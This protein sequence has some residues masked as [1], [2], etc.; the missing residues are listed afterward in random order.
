MKVFIGGSRKIKKLNAQIEDRLYNI[1]NNNYHVLLGDAEGADK[2]VQH[3]FYKQRYSNVN[4]FCSGD[5]CRNNLGHWDIINIPVPTNFRGRKFY[6]VKD[7]AM[8]ETSDYGFMLWDGTSPGTLN[9][10]LNL[11]HL[12]KKTLVYFH[13]DNLFMKISKT[14][15]LEGLLK[16]CSPSQFQTLDKKLHLRKYMIIQQQPEQIS[17]TSCINHQGDK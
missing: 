11:L 9:N 7:A 3:F 17:L 13:P 5:N 10:V 16:R 15:D 4:V 8:A 6:T 2:T 14:S 1:L 12:K